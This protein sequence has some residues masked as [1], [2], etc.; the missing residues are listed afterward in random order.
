MTVPIEIRQVKRPLNTVVIDTKLKSS[1][2][3]AVKARNGFYKKSD[4]TSFPKNG[5][6]I[7]H[8]IDNKFVPI[9]TTKIRDSSYS[10]CY[11]PSAFIKSVSQDIYDDLL[12][13]FDVNDA[14]KIFVIAALKVIK[15]S[16]SAYRI[17]TEYKRHYL[18]LLYPHAALS[19]NTVGS[20]YERIGYNK[21]LRQDFF[22]RRME[23][24]KETHN[25]IIDG[26]LKKDES[27]VND[28]SAYSRK[29]R[30]KKYKEI[31]IM[32]AYDTTLCEPIC[33]QV[34]PGN[35]LDLK[36]A[37][38]FIETNNI[39]KGT[40]VAD[41]GFSVK[42]FQNAFKDNPEL[43]FVIPL[44]NND[45][46][47]RD[48]NMLERKEAFYF[49]RE[50]VYGKKVKIA[51]N[52]F[53]YSYQNL[54]MKI[55]QEYNLHKQCN[56]AKNENDFSKIDNRN[57]YCGF[58]IF[59]SDLDLPLEKIYSIYRDRWK[60]EMVFRVY[61]ND[62]LLQTTRCH[63]DFSVIGLEFV[64]LIA[65]MITCRLIKKGEESGLLDKITFGELM[66]EIRSPWRSIDAPQNIKPDVNDGYWENDLKKGKEYLYKLDLVTD[67][68]QEM[69]IPKKRGRKRIYPEF[70][71]PKRPKGRP[72]TRVEFVGP[73][74]PRGRPS[75]K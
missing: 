46:R 13:C 39:T 72:K 38:S 52:R 34:F 7:G 69:Y 20:L 30:I 44:K 3:Y 26:T 62:I 67:K 53:L 33:S 9:S 66:D 43:H 25:L 6:V 56:L 75:K 15:P 5:S 65:T 58:I 23:K 29:S 54:K 71:G 55:S 2:R 27:T 64:N 24:V 14:L 35:M 49:I 8:I 60:L 61:K 42:E 17:S 1:K 41:K 57:K 59:E 31:S 45:I 73:K 22:Q 21:E 51:E 74:R 48:Y 40:L 47:I 10:L 28:L 11:G 12:D 63:N 70:V 4:G 37:K 32:Y 68:I 50:A 16:I 18:S 19:K 36:A